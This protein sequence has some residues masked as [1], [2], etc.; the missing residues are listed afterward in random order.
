MAERYGIVAGDAHTAMGDVKTM[1]AVL[2]AM[3][4]AFAQ[5]PQLPAHL[6]H[7]SRPAPGPAR[8]PP[9]ALRPVLKPRRLS[10]AAP[11][12]GAA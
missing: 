5:D 12:A 6:A 2:G 10:G 4:R 9:L 8:W 1:S 11:M 3:L 7:A